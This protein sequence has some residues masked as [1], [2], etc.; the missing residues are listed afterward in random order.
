MKKHSIQKILFIP[1]LFANVECFG[2]YIEPS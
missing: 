2:F 1:E